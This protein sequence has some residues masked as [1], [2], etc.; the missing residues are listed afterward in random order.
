MS[1]LAIKGG[2]PVRVK[3]ISLWPIFDGKEKE[4][5]LKVLES[6]EWGK[7]SGNINTEFEEKFSRFQDAKH[8]IT[9]C[10]GTVAIRIAL[11]A[12]GV[13]PGDEVIVPSYTFVA[14]ASAVLEANAIPVFADIDDNTFN[15]LPESVEQLINEHT[16]AIMPVHFGGAPSP[17]L[18][19]IMN[20]AE[21]NNLIIIEDAAQAQGSSFRGRRVGALGTAGTFSFQSSKNI[22]SGEG[23]AIVT[24]DDLTAEKLRS[25]HNC[26]RKPGYPW[27][28]HFG[29]S[30]NFRLSEFQAAILLAQLEREESNLAKRRENAKY[31]DKLLTD[32]EGIEPAVYPDDIQSSYY[33][34][35]MKYRKES[36]NSLSKE[37]FVKALNAEGIS[38]LEGY[39]FP[40]YKQPIFTEQNFWNNYCPVNCSFYKK[41]I[42]YTKSWNPTSEQICKTGFWFPNTVLHGS[43]EDI[44]DI[45]EAINKIKKYSVELMGDDD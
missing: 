15:L 24:N 19:K 16:K 33:L 21:R 25:F 18:D 45:V 36:F 11:Y 3:P 10:N 27:Y 34:Y 31:L 40:L 13:G 17:Y 42:D 30:G 28:F 9:V 6:R 39:P 26:G 7:I 23:G 5:L 2:T 43:K 44:D 22:T 29:V 37:N 35:V 4:Y 41:T 12:A 38:T 8:A 14:T 20:I 32:V 1:K